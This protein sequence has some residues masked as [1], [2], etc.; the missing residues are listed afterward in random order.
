MSN[1]FDT[2]SSAKATVTKLTST[3]LLSIFSV[4]GDTHGGA[5]KRYRGHI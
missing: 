5:M 4:L 3:R 2:S 1:R